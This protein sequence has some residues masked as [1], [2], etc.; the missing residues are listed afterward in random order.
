M[1]RVFALIGVA[2]VFQWLDSIS[3]RGF[4]HGW[5]R[6]WEEGFACGISATPEE[7][8]AIF[9]PCDEEFEAA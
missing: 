4:D 7:E 6:G 2:A 3:H 8:A 1:Y 9:P 5:S